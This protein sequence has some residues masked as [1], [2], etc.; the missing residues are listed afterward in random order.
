MK[1]S[2][3]NEKKNRAREWARW[4][5]QPVY[6]LSSLKCV[7]ELSLIAEYGVGRHIIV[8]TIADTCGSFFKL[9]TYS[10]YWR[11][12]I[13]IKSFQCGQSRPECLGGSA[14]IT[15]RASAGLKLI[16]LAVGER[17]LKKFHRAKR[18][19]TTSAQCKYYENVV[20]LVLHYNNEAIES[21]DSELKHN[22]IRKFFSSPHST[23]NNIFFYHHATIIIIKSY[24]TIVS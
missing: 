22:I 12:S 10:K 8:H 9:K 1:N 15:G 6:L 4:R 11:R 13:I 5:S 14:A 7:P 2:L 3:S 21:M 18:C 20:Q 17:T 23:Y 24:R 16:R 19:R